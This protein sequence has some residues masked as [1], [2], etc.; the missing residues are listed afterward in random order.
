ML[1]FLNKA[2]VPTSGSISVAAGAGVTLGVKAGDPLFYELSDIDALLTSGNLGTGTLP[3]DALAGIDTT[4]GDVTYSFTGTTTRGLAKSGTGVLTLSG[5]NTYSGPTAIFGGSISITAPENLGDGSATNGIILG[6]GTLTM[7]TSDFQ[8]GVNRTLSV[9]SSG[10]LQVDSGTLIVDGPVSGAGSLTKA[11]AGSMRIDGNATLTGGVNVN[12]GILQSGSA[13]VFS[14]TSPLSVA[15]GATFDM[16]GFDA[17]VRSLANVAGSIIS[18]AG[19]TGVNLLTVAAQAVD[20]TNALITDDGNRQIQ[21]SFTSNGVGAYGATTNASNTYSG[22]LL[23]GNLIRAQVLTNAVGTPGNI[24]SGPF[25]RGTITIN[26]GNTNATG[27]QIWFSTADRTLTNHVIVN[28]NA[29]NGNRSGSFRI[30]AT[31]V[32]ITGNITASG[33]DCWFGADA[34]AVLTLNG[35][36]TGPRGFRFYQSNGTAAWTAVLNNLT[37]LENDYVGNTNIANSQTTLRL[38]A[39]NQIPN[40]SGRGNVTLTAGTLDLNGFDETING[41]TGAGTIDNVAAGSG[42]TLTLG[43]GN[44]SPIDAFTGVIRNT[45][46][47]LS[48]TKIGSGT[49]TFSAAQAYTG[50][51]SVL[52]GALAINGSL[53]AASAVLVGG[54]VAS[55]SPTLCGTGTVPGSVTIAAADGGAAGRVNPGAVGAIGTLNVGPTTIAGTLAVDLNATTSDV[56][57]VTGNLDL[58]GSSLAVNALAEPTAN[59]YT[60]ITYTGNLSGALTVQ[61]SL[62]VGYT[63]DYSTPGQVN[64]VQQPAAGYD[65]WANTNQIS[66]GAGGDHD[67]D[68]IPNLVEYALGL[69]AAA[70]NASPGTFNGTEISFSKGAEVSGVTYVIETSTTLGNDWTPVTPTAEDASSIRYTLPV[71]QTK[72]FARLKVTQAE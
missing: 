59:S 49:Q 68:G 60:L 13:T 17:S 46:G 27:A 14:G 11:G 50:T 51:T 22:G 32:A 39:A 29:G 12:A 67:G 40:G 70:P 58:N 72:V 20:G 30:G 71:G 69:N 4:A 5:S 42:N 63:L 64:L 65:A 19:T 9:V 24:V 1:A 2:S 62:P 45:T 38:G 28:G 16:N 61:G 6:G 10:T 31:N 43:D 48:V 56:L 37:G 53:N 54:A 35:Q 47:T 23:L 57:A 8:L 15:V 21:L 33:T 26:G 34:A 25:G 36:L 52:G 41:L 18:S 3:A 66:G 44:A 7:P 55:G